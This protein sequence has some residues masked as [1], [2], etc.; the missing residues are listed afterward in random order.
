MGPRQPGESCGPGEWAELGAQFTCSRQ[1][2]NGVQ[3]RSLGDFGEQYTSTAPGWEAGQGD[4][5][6]P[7]YRVERFGVWS[8]DAS[9]RQLL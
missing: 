5:A 1:A 2:V 9:G 7:H 4:P 6:V 8:L 3:V